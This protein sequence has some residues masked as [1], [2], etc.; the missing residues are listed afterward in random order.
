MMQRIENHKTPVVARRILGL[1][2][3]TLEAEPSGAFDII[4]HEADVRGTIRCWCPCGCGNFMV[5]PIRRAGV[6]H[7]EGRAEWEWDG[8]ADK[9]TLQPSIRDMAMCR[10]HGFLTGGVWTFCEDSGVR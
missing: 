6:P 4:E 8:N 3:S 7:A 9:P 2:Y 5:L 1:D 10:F